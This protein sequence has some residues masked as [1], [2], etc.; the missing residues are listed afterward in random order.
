VEELADAGAPVKVAFE[1]GLHEQRPASSDTVMQQ[2]LG[3]P[4]RIWRRPDGKPVIQ[5][6]EGVSAAHANDFTL[7]VAGAGGA[8][9]DLEEVTARA[10]TVWRDLLGEEKFKL[11]ERIALE[12][13]ESVDAAG[14]R[15]W[16]AL[17]CLKKIGQ[18]V[19][20]PLVLESSTDDGWTRLRSGRVTI[21]TCVTAVRGMKSPL[22]LAVAFEPVAP[23]RPSSAVAK[24]VA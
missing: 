6:E 11:A 2:A 23:S 4:E 24:M 14:T 17:E 7:A 18:P 9:C 8:A 16:T 10:A 5:G 19:Q 3:R 13:V 15:L 22:G 12:R 1:R 20:S 21:M